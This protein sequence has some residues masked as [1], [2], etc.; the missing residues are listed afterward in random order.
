MELVIDQPFD[1]A[2]HVGGVIAQRHRGEL[3][4]RVHQGA[5]HTVSFVIPESE[6]D[7]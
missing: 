6:R 5:C 3:A 4:D 7:E 2:G 1:L